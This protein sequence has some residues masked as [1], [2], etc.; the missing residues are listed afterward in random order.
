MT[1]HFT[2]YLLI[3]S[4]VHSI[5]AA[6]SGAYAYLS[7]FFPAQMRASSIAFASA[8]ASLSIIYMPI[9]GILLNRFHLEIPVTETYTITGWRLHMLINLIP[10]VISLVFMHS[11]PESPK[12]LMSVNRTEEC[13]LVL[14]TMYE[15]NTKESRF[16]FP[17]RELKMDRDHEE[18]SH[19]SSKSL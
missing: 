1:V 2:C 3:S 13:L 19:K 17:V 9:V 15:T 11:L 6:S 18:G 5:A 16:R 8:V 10:G 12:F 4:S 7:E 14:R